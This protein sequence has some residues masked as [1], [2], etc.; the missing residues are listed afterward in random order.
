MVD[1]HP[2][3]RSGIRAMLSRE[4]GI[5]VIAEAGTGEDAVR[6]AA[7]LAP[8]VVLCDLRLGP[9]LDG[10]GVTRD[11]R[12]RADGPAVVILT[13]YDHDRDILRAVEAG[14]AG[15]LLKDAPA[16]V[17][18]AAI[19]DAAG[20]GSDL[21]PELV[22]RVVE[23]LRSQPPQLSERE[24]AVLARVAQG[25]TNRQVARA[26]FVSEATVKTH[27]VHVFAKLGVDSRTAAVARAR[28]LGLLD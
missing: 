11:C 26:L 10:V 15:Y 14:A 27:L 22:D 17:I 28:D 7:E 18:A 23:S 16:D 2:V 21:A 8:Q 3:V 9:G 12:T 20:G 25:G 1:D 6:L 19:R 5:E 24:M 4:P 13:T